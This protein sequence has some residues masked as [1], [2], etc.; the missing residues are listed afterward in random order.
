MKQ[1]SL[2]PL[3]PRLFI[4]YCGPTPYGPG[5]RQPHTRLGPASA[6]DGPA[7]I[8]YNRPTITSAAQ[9]AYESLGRGA[10]VIDTAGMAADGG[11]PAAYFTQQ[12]IRRYEDAAIDRLVK[13]YTPGEEQR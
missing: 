8:D 11:H 5:T 6:L 1:R 7:R 4:C 9:I 12:E 13:D 2:T 3:E 10:I